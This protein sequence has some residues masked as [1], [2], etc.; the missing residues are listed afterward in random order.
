[1]SP[2]CWRQKPCDWFPWCPP[3]F[4]QFQRDEGSAIVECRSGFN[5]VHLVGQCVLVEAEHLEGFG[6]LHRQVDVQPVQPGASQSLHSMLKSSP[7]NRLEGVGKGF[8]GHLE[9]TAFTR[10]WFFNAA[11]YRLFITSH[12]LSCMVLVIVG[13]RA[14]GKGMLVIGSSSEA[15]PAE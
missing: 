15:Q 6:K 2:T 8:A 1:M 7:I 10:F 9:K 5:L 11:V 13:A 4:C 14:G 12:Q 3:L